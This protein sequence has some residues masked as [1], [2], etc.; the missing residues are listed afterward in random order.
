MSAD[1]GD[2]LDSPTLEH[3]IAGILCS[4]PAAAVEHFAFPATAWDVLQKPLSPHVCPLSAEFRRSSKAFLAAW[5]A[6]SVLSASSLLF[7]SA[8]SVVSWVLLMP[9]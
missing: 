1:L 7:L 6:L 3:Q 8:L 5:F 2:T 9:K 4:L